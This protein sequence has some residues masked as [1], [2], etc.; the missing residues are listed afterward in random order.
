MKTI[1]MIIAAA[2]ALAGCATQPSNIEAA[3][4]PSSAYS[5]TACD[6]LEADIVEAEQALAIAIAQQQSDAD[7]DAVAM[8]VAL[9]LFAPAL[10]VLAATDDNDEAIAQAKG[11]VNAMKAEANRRC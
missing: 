3:Y 10:L 2:L 5:E 1:T 11:Q 4:V 6:R 9:V 8:G 7:T